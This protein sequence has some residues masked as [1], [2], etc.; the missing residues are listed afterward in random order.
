MEHSN[1][2]VF[3]VDE[4]AKTLNIG[5]NS[6]YQAVKNGEIPSIKIGRRILIPVVALEKML[7]EAGK[8]NSV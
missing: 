6:A 8:G 4:A 2:K 5:L 3:T 7:S 1:M